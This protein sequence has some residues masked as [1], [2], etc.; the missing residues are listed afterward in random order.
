MYDVLCWGNL[1]IG[2]R[3]L[4]FGGIL[5]ED[6]VRLE[7]EAV[8]RRMAGIKFSSFTTYK[9]VLQVE[10]YIK[11]N[12]IAGASRKCARLKVINEV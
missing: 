8:L 10:Y 1:S 5:I 6:A 11:I 9:G 3:A 7:S 12:D 4:L 2:A